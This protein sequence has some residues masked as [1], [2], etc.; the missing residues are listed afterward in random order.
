MSR[1]PFILVFTL[2]LALFCSSSQAVQILAQDF[3]VGSPPSG[4]TR[5]H[6][7]L[8]VGFA[9][10]TDLGSEFFLVPAH[11]RYAASNDDGAGQSNSADR[12]R[13]ITPQLNL[14]TYSGQAILLKFQYVGPNIYGS[15]THVEASTDGGS[16]WINLQTLAPAGGWTEGNVLVSAYAGMSNVKFAFRHNDNG[17]WADGM[18]VDDVLIETLVAR[19]VELRRLSSPEYVVPGPQQI[20]A[21]VTNRG[22]TPAASIGLRYRVANGA[23]QNA[24]IGGLSLAV[25]QTAEITHP[26]QHTF[27]APGDFAVDLGITSVN[28]Q[29]DL[30][31]TNDNASGTVHVLT[32]LPVKKVVLEQHTGTWCQFCPDATVYWNQLRASSPNVIAVSVHNSDAMTIADAAPLQAAYVSGYPSGTVDR[33]KFEG[34]SVVEVNRNGWPAKVD[35]RLDQIVPV[36]VSLQGVSYNPQTRQL[37]ATVRAAFAGNASGDQRLNLWVVEDAVYGASGYNQTNYYN[38][39]AGHPYFGAGNP[40]VNFRHDGVVRVMLAGPWGLSNSVA[41]IVFTG[42]TYNHTFG[43]QLP[44]GVNASN[45]RL[46]GLLQAYDDADNAKRSIINATELELMPQFRDGFE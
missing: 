18:A 2:L 15:T 19:D 28:G 33:V 9:F 39:V 5:T 31:A 12:D 40:I 37:S 13:L 23:W 16:N 1:R 14:S 7:P 41:P 32:S 27:A 44:A 8:S 3:E 11:T 30:N 46:I 6:N 21:E 10:G 25:G 43:M 36:E 26:V 17:G 34:A 45:V 22:G 20:R 42:E 4:W 35:A 24:T 38:T 29:T